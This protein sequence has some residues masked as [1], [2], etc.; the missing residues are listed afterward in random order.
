MGKAKI[1]DYYKRFGEWAKNDFK[2]AIYVLSFCLKIG[3]KD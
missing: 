2:K 1:L 3:T